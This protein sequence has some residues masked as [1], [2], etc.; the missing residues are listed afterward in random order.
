[1]ENTNPDMKEKECQFPKCKKKFF[2]RGKTKYCNE[3]RKQKY[4]KFLYK[5][6]PS[7]G[8]G[9]NVVIKHKHTEIQEEIHNCALEGCT[10]MFNLTLIPNQTIYPKYCNDHR[11]PYKREF[12][13]KQQQEKNDE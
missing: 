13:T 10:E 12:F 7:D 8:I 11:N 6:Q 5:K 4:K 2:G 9:S 1:M 3:H